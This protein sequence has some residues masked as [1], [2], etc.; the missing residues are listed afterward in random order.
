MFE[1]D[2]Y[3]YFVTGSRVLALSKLKFLKIRS[4]LFDGE[5]KQLPHRMFMN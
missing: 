2:S 5:I 1:G 4:V 3:L